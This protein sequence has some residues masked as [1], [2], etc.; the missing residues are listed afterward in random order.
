[1]AETKK[2][3]YVKCPYCDSWEEGLADDEPLCNCCWGIGRIIRLVDGDSVR[4]E[5]G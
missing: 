2:A 5:A 1:M 3:E 4:K